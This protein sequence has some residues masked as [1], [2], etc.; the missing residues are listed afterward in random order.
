MVLELVA[1]PSAS[2]LSRVNTEPLACGSMRM[3]RLFGGTAP[4]KDDR[5]ESISQ[6]PSI[7]AAQA[8]RSKTMRKRVVRTG[9]CALT[10]RRS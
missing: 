10:G 1:R 2:I 3:V 8:A 4:M 9:A 5:A 7:E 6:V